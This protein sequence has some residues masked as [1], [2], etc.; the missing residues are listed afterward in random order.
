MQNSKSQLYQIINID[1]YLE[2]GILFLE[3]KWFY[4]SVLVSVASTS[5]AT[6]T[7]TVVAS[8]SVTSAAA[9][10]SGVSSTSTVGASTSANLPI[11]DR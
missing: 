3:F 4:F 9:S 5:G 7:S 6:S 1:N 10:T 8:T 11:G 2:F